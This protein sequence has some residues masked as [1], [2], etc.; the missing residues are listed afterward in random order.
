MAVHTL[1][2]SPA[3][4]AELVAPNA[5]VAVEVDTAGSAELEVDYSTGAAL[6][7]GTVA[8]TLVVG[9]AL[10]LAPSAATEDFEADTIGQPPANFTQRTT[11]GGITVQSTDSQQ[12]YYGGGIIYRSVYSFNNGPSSADAE[13]L[14]RVKFLDNADYHGGVCLRLTG[15]GSSLR[16][17]CVWPQRPGGNYL[18][19][20]RFTGD[21]SK[22]DITSKNVGFSFAT[23][24][25]YWVRYRIDGTTHRAKIWAD[26]SLEPAWQITRTDATH[27]G[28]GDTGLFY[29]GGTYPRRVFLDDV[30]ALGS[31]ASYAT[32]GTWTG[33]ADSLAAVGDYSFSRLT[34]TE[35]KPA[36]SS[37]TVEARV[38]GGT[39][40]AVS[41]GGE[42][43][44]LALNDDL[45]SSTLELRVTLATT[46]SG[47]T[48]TVSNLV[49]EFVP[50]DGSAV[51]LVV[52]GLSCTLANGRLRQAG[53][54]EVVSGAVVTGYDRTFASAG[55]FY[56]QT[57]G[58]AVAAAFKYNGTTLGS[59]NFSL[60]RLVDHREAGDARFLFPPVAAYDSLPALAHFRT[61]ATENVFS[62]ADAHLRVLVRGL[63]LRGDLSFYV[64]SGFEV[65]FPG[66]VT[67]ASPE[68]VDV[69]GELI[70]RGYARDDFPAELLAQGYRHDDTSGELLAGVFRRFD[71]SGSELA[72]VLR[73]HDHPAAVLVYGVNR[74][75]VL[76]LVVLSESTFNALTG[77]GY[78][79]N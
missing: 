47:V 66:T 4:A 13:I 30:W 23:Y 15:S 67:A 10:T 46:D 11:N 34:W 58:Q 78:G 16:G 55:L 3:A 14:C 43:P 73:H 8:G 6:N 56:F 42:L 25:W 5:P 65:D 40:T 20:S 29:S 19:F 27:T 69:L 62:A 71:F 12:A 24:V 36:G 50:L 39:W 57:D 52:G 54:L 48:P 44:D 61:F 41:N 7:T 31:P 64:A 60:E 76:E 28:P 32:S 51:E 35:D 72:G 21:G 22:A 45:S 63:V 17:Y 49:A 2:W 70:V 75:N 68:V 9:D 37:V 1:T 18:I 33:P 77:R 53:D 38:D 59:I 74:N 26:G 79:F